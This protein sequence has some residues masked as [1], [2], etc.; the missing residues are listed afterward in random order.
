MAVNLNWPLVTWQAA[1]NADPNDPAAVPVWNDLSVRLRT[2]DSD[3]GRQYESDTNQAGEAQAT[4]DDLDELLNPAN[5]ASAYNSGSNLILPLRP[6]LHQAMWPPLPVGS[7]VNMINL[8]AGCDPTFDSYTV[9]STPTWVAASATTVAA[10]VKV[11]NVSPRSGANDM[12]CN[13]LAGAAVQ[14]VGFSVPCI[15]GRQYTASAYCRT[16]ASETVQISVAGGATGGSATAN[17]TYTRISVT[18]TATLQTHVIQV[19]TVGTVTGSNLR[20]DDIQLEPG[21]STSTFSSAIGPV[22]YGV[23]A[24]YVERWPST[25]DYNGIRGRCD[26]TCVDGLAAFAQIPLDAEYANAVLAKAPDLYWRLNDGDATTAYTDSSGHGGPSLVPIVS[27]YG[28]GSSTLAGGGSLDVAGDPNGTGAEFN[29][30]T[31]ADI[32]AKRGQFLGYGLGAGSSSPSSGQLAVPAAIGS[33]WSLTVAV[34]IVIPPG[35]AATQPFMSIVDF[36]GGVQSV[37]TNCEPLAIVLQGGGTTATVGVGYQSV[38]NGPGMDTIGSAVVNDGLPH[39]LVATISQANGGNTTAQSWVDGVLDSTKTVTTASCG[40]LSRQ[41]TSVAIGGIGGPANAYYTGGVADV[42]TGTIGHVAMWNRVLSNAEIADLAWAGTGYVGENSGAR[43]SRLVAYGYFGPVNIDTGAS[44][45]GVSQVQADSSLLDA[46]QFITTSENG[47]FWIDQNGVA[48]FRSRTSRYL[49]TAATW[50]LGE[51]AAGGE[52]PYEQG[53]LF[54]FDPTQIY[55]QVVV[56]RTGGIVATAMDAASQ[57]SYFP[58]KFDLEIGVQSDL[59]AID[60]SNWQLANH[61][62]P[63]Q[64]VSGVQLH[65]SANPALWPVA[66]GIRKNDRVTVN[67]RT[68]AGVVMS[69]DYFVERIEHAHSPGEWMTSLELSPAPIQPWILGDA[70]WGQLGITTILGY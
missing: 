37:A 66:L 31:A 48:Q 20:I 40:F 15:P 27:K 50:A 64:R 45:M 51:N 5:A 24:G 19:L 9:G 58:R 65:P 70:T 4:L 49:E 14:G 28:A 46:V 69:G 54:D 34:W 16:S 44:T 61:K 2:W 29:F 21:A 1:F 62:Q 11:D 26:I 41:A 3:F 59:E 53:I 25:W 8:T 13:L 22:I 32:T 30:G 43:I 17:A 55:N 35:N 63:K 23:S 7:A 67:R 42:A 39:L 68:S 52:A 33:S 57:K 47:D 10:N 18:F 38:V 60:A 12:F 6:Y 36:E 56:T